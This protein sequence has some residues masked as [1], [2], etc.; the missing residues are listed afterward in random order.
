MINTCGPLKSFLLRPFS[1]V[2]SLNT[3]NVPAPHQ[4]FGGEL[5]YPIVAVAAA[6]EEF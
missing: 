4:C 1:S 2:F 3:P 6:T 5:N